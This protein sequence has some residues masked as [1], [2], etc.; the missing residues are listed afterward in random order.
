ML[1]LH[2]FNVVV[3]FEF[4]FFKF[5]FK[6]N[7]FE[8]LA[9]KS[10]FQPKTPSRPSIF[11]SLF[12]PPAQSRA[13]AGPSAP[14][15]PVSPTGGSRS[16]DPSPSR[17]RAGL[18]RVR[19][20]HAPSRRGPHAKGPRP[21]P[22]K[23][24]AHTLEPYPTA[25]L[26]P[27]A[28]TLAR[29]TAAPLEPLSSVPPPTR[30]SAAS[31]RSPAAA[32]AQICGEDPRQPLR[33]L[34]LAL[35]HRRLLAGVSA[36]RYAVAH[37]LPGPAHARRGLHRPPHHTRDLPGV[38]PAPNRARSADFSNSGDPRRRSPSH[39]VAGS[40]QRRAEPPFRSTSHMSVCSRAILPAEP[41]A[42]A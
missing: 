15:P 21:R 26:F 20:P 13:R 4:E 3:Q 32:R 5:E 19:A 38:S 18:R 33:P 16:S 8:S 31:L 40:A 28:K 24:A 9:K 10:L 2:C 6:L 7:L 17:A 35:S 39:V 27:L 30:R 12:P 25:A 36:P 14:S 23:G 22:I 29:A 41:R 37:H 42:D 11:P 1:P 34:S